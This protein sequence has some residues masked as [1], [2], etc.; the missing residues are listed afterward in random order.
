MR[1][2]HPT[3]GIVSQHRPAGPDTHITQEEG[4]DA[5]IT[6]I[7]S[8]LQSD[9]SFRL[10]RSDMSAQVRCENVVPRPLEKAFDDRRCQAFVV[11]NSWKLACRLRRFHPDIAISLWLHLQ[12]GRHNRHMGRALAKAGI[13]VIC[14][15]QS[16]ARQLKAFLSDG[17]LPRISHIRNPIPDDL[18]PDDTPRDL[19][20]LLLSCPPQKRLA[21]VLQQFAALRERMPDL[22]LEVADAGDL[23]CHIGP[24]PKG[25]WLRGSLPHDRLVARMRRVLC[26]FFPQTSLGLLIAEANAVGTPVLLQR[27]LGASAGMVNGPH[28][29]TRAMTLDRLES[30]I[31]SWQADF[32]QIQAHPDVR[33]SS[34]AQKWR[35]KLTMMIGTEPLEAA[36]V[37]SGR[38]GISSKEASGGQA[39]TGTLW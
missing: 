9:F 12:P 14:V 28:R 20:R 22:T 37:V 30:R 8:A 38:G 7:V 33:L 2:A 29:L 19:N 32:P 35:Q 17:P 27:G 25:V 31:R 21:Q 6:K 26:L 24:V 5:A 23:T 1:A 36:D 34:V 11:I 39:A 4:A 3:I 10:F 13:D 16:H 15:S 18:T